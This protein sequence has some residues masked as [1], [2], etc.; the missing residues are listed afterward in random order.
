MLRQRLKVSPI[1]HAD[2]HLSADRK[3]QLLGVLIV[4]LS[5]AHGCRSHKPA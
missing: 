2:C 4:Q 1:M 5:F 3:G